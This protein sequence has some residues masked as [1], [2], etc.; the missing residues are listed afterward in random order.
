M[1]EKVIMP[2]AGMAMEEGKIIRW[3]KKEGDS[4]EKGEPI[5]EIETDKVNM[6]VESMSSGILLKIIGQDGDVFPVTDTIGYIGEKNEEISVDVAGKID[7]GTHDF[8]DEETSESKDQ[9]VLYKSTGGKVAATP[10]AKRLAKER[11]INLQTVNGT[12]I[13]GEIRIRDIEAIEQQKITPLAKKMSQA[14]GIDLDNVFGTGHQGKIMKADILQLLEGRCEEEASAI[15]LDDENTDADRVPLNGMRKVIAER[16][17]RSHTE[18]PPVTMNMK[19]DVTSLSRYR[20]EI[21]DSLGIKLSYNDFILK[22]TATALSE[23]PYVNA[24]I[25]GDEIVYKKDINVGMAV[26]LDEGLIVP[27]IRKTDTMS[28][29][30][31]SERAKDLASKAREGKL[32][33]DEYT[34]GTF[35]VSNLG[36]Y[37][38]TSFTPIINQPESAILGVC[39]I[40]KEINSKWR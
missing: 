10:V 33:P 5:L 25:E 36:M 30:M 38:V 9:V 39:A 12:G 40:E 18:I 17:L 16:M 6:E 28:M 22:A 20:K 23:M 29:K 27:V 32:M 24:S 11:N 21:N 37:S 19:A 14:N 26:A 7:I 34:G 8:E 3:F 31:L 15:V 35:T 1:A 2:K 4:I 13:H